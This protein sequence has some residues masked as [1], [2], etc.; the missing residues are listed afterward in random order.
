MEAQWY[1]ACGVAYCW[2]SHLVAIRQNLPGGIVFRYN[3][4][5]LSIIIF[6]FF[7]KQ[8]CLCPPNNDTVKVSLLYIVM[9]NHKIA[10]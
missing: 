4:Y 7:E 2:G 6:F 10:R 1:F 9:N 8:V 5:R 3:G